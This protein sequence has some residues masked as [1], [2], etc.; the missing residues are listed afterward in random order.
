MQVQHLPGPAHIP[1]SETDL[2]MPHPP[3]LPEEEE[4]NLFL[5]EQKLMVTLG[6]GCGVQASGDSVG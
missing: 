6:M 2:P 4:M 5:S 1:P 3:S